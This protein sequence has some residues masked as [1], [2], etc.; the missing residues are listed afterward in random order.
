MNDAMK[1]IKMELRGTK[2]FA[3]QGEDGQLKVEG[4][5]VEIRYQKEGKSYFANPKNL[6]VLT[7][8]TPPKKSSLKT[9]KVA[10][11]QA[12]RKHHESSIQSDA[13]TVVAY[14][15]GACSGNPGPA[16]MGAVVQEGDQ[17]REL[18]EYLGEGTNNIAELKVIQRV[19]ESVEDKSKKLVIYSDS[20]YAAGVLQEGW[21]AKANKELIADVKAALS[22]FQFWEIHY[23]KAHAGI[24]LN[25]RA[26]ELAVQASQ[27]K[28][29]QGWQSV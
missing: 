24:E 19:A 7:Q 5:K 26:D 20:K 2:V 12:S 11:A 14:V 22:E 13:S 6:E 10:S 8:R 17:V 28:R 23:V 9:S 1:W 25:E 16:G 29:S 18:S 3:L 21:K 15:D 27:E 4:G